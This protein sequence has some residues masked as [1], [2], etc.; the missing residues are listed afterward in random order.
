MSPF[1]RRLSLCLLL[2]VVAAALG[3]CW[4]RRELDQ[5]GIQLGTSIDRTGNEY[6][7]AVQVVIPGEVSS[8]MGSSTRSPVTLFKATAPTIFEAFRK[9]TETS[10]RKIYSAHIRVV[11]I[12]E[13]V[14]RAGIADVLDLFSRNPEAR[15]D[16]YLMIAR[17]TPAVQVLETLT[18][19]EK[20]PAEK[21]FYSLDTSAKAWSP[22]T[23]VT[24]DKIINQLVAEGQS[25]VLTGVTI[26]GNSREGERITNI[27]Q[28]EPKARTRFN[29]LAVFKQ[30]KLKGWL[31]EN[32]SRGYNYIKNN[33]RS[34]G[35]H[36]VCPE[37]GYVGLETLRNHTVMHA[38]VVNGEPV[39]RLKITNVSAVSDVECAIDLT[40][41]DTIRMLEKASEKKLIKIVEDTIEHVRT[42]YD[43]DV[44][45]FGQALYQSHPRVWEK[46]KHDWPQRLRT[47]KVEVKAR[48]LIHKIG[49]TNHS[50]IKDIKE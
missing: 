45:G 22:T 47:L 11:I 16:F 26:E 33:V 32:E 2:G 38:D 9:L 10:P 20:I 7:I 28:I 23:T 36:V 12:S 39:I 4:N 48:V 50:F 25:P 19:L 30:D 35:G 8:R 3:G 40:N 37:G 49:T 5:L 17:N 15:T 41:P 18:S 6:S 31:D 43:F 24:I 13:A 44:F 1:I 29:M 46:V 42:T 27:Q 34:S 21:L 14:A